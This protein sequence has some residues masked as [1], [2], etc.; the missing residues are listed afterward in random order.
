M[1][2]HPQH[3]ASLNVAI[4]AHFVS[5]QGRQADALGVAY[6]FTSDARL[7]ARSKLDAQGHASLVGR[8][9]LKADALRV[10]VGPDLPEAQ[11]SLEELIR[12][13]GVEHHLNWRDGVVELKASLT[14]FEPM[15]QC[16][17]RSAV[18]VQGTLVKKALI[19]GTF[20]ELPVCHA[21]VEVYEVDPLHIVLPR[22][23]DWVLDRIRDILVKGELPVLVEPRLPGP[24]P[25]PGPDPLPLLRTG[26]FL[27]KPSQRATLADQGHAFTP[28]S[29]ATLQHLS[30]ATELRYVAQ[31]GSRAQFQ[32]ALVQN[33][34]LLR[35][36]LCR[37]FPRFVT[38]QKV[39]TVTTD[40][41]G[42]FKA[43]FF[44]GCHNHDTPDLYFKASQPLF[45]PLKVTIHAP[46]PVA[47]HTWWDYVSGTEVKLVTTHPLAHTCAPCPPVVGPGGHGRWVAFL[48]IG[49]VPLSQI[50]GT[51][52]AL[53]DAHSAAFVNE[54]LGQTADGRPFGG[55]LRPR[56]LF[57]NELQAL[58][59]KHYRVSWRRGSAGDFVPLKDGIQHYYRHDVKTP[60]G[61][62]PAWTPYTLGP[63]PVASGGG[64]FEPDLIEVPYPSVAPEGVWDTPP[65]GGEVVEHLS[66]AKFPT[67]AFSRGL[68]WQADGTPV[69]GTV[70]ESGAFQLKVDLFDGN[71]HP[72][73]IGALDIR[74]VVPD[75]PDLSGTIATFDAASLGL[76][77]GNSM[78]ITLRVDNN[79]C[80]AQIA[81][82]VVGAM[83][84]DDCCGVLEVADGDVVSLGYQAWHP[85]GFAN[86]SFVTVRGVN[87]VVERTHDPA[88]SG[89]PLRVDN[90]DTAV[91]EDPTGGSPVNVSVHD[92]LTRNLPAHCDPDGC[93]VAGFSENLYVDSTATDG[94]NSELGYDASAVRAFV[95]SKIPVALPSTSPTPLP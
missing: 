81:P 3:A 77:S 66:S 79:R 80:F 72:V 47:C 59:V 20:V 58:G 14:V 10:V 84:A 44:Q 40:D 11:A 23:P 75:V 87:P 49:G 30:E 21:T 60:G 8:P 15:W 19:G 74:F 86:Y 73:D 56:L 54:R 28:D 67:Q 43:L 7:L 94:W 51:S 70:D 55:L 25:E 36:L 13:G 4:K 76:V 95:L 17:W 39:A 88:V 1:A 9:A 5:L 33:P 31:V 78:V 91:N 63:K 93:L 2:S 48:A 65:A 52:R 46:T 26:A 61:V 53:R 32:S 64:A 41:C 34:V 90:P 57:A 62:F 37:L 24:I 22:L 27:R 12:R 69:P 35:P 83:A 38:M 82:P 89:A 45:G 71:G 50:F 42:H 16:W 92:L 85:H 18:F 29:V 68:S 6:L